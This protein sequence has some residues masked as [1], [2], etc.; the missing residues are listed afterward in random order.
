MVLGLGRFFLPTRLRL[1][2][3]LTS[4]QGEATSP[5]FALP[6]EGEQRCRRRRGA[7]EQDEKDAEDEQDEEEKEEQEA[8]VE[9]EW[10]DGGRG[11]ERQEDEGQEQDDKEERIDAE[12]D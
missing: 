6:T 3:V 7:E 4:V 8:K 5:V 9:R 11:R 1:C 10:M 2:N 12:T